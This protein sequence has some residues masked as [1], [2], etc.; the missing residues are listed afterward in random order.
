M[1]IQSEINR[2]I[3]FRDL[4]FE[5]VRDK[6]VS[7]PSDAII[8]DLPDYIAAIPTGSGSAITIQ[9][10][11]DSHG[12]T[13]R[14]ITAVSLAGDTVSPSTLLSGYTAHNSLGEAIVGTASGGGGT[15]QAKTNIAP[16]E[17]SQTIRPDTGYD[18]LSSVQINAVSS[19]YVGT[20]VTRKSA[21][22]ITPTK[23][24]QAIASGTYLTGT[25]TIAAIPA[26]YQDVTQVD[27]T[28]GDVA[29]GKKI[30]NSSG[31]VVTG[32]LAFQTIYSGSSAPSS[33]TG[34][35][36]DVYIQTA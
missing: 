12:G 16:T 32:T 15:Y 33:S 20:G 35:N 25:Q 24:T 6:G 17:S 8:D 5:A 2:I 3:N 30:V 9:D 26:A 13:H 11:A 4:S 19:T 31:T 34:V 21:A 28:A 10:V 36:G 7:V 14:I 23:S 27:A 18:A 1:S 22:T 29:S